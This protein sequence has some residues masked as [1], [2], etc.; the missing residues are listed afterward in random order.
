MKLDKQKL[1][2]SFV[3]SG[4]YDKSIYF[5]ILLMCVS[6]FTEFAFLYADTISPLIENVFIAFGI[7][8][9]FVGVIEGLNYFGL[10][11]SLVCL[12]NGSW[13]SALIVFLLIYCAAK[14]V[15]VGISIGGAIKAVEYQ[16]QPP[17][18]ITQVY[19]DSIQNYYTNK[20]SELMASPHD[21]NQAKAD[22]LKQMNKSILSE[23]ESL[24]K[25]K[26]NYVGEELMYRVRKIISN[27][28]R[29]INK[30][31][32]KIN[33]I[34]SSNSGVANATEQAQKMREE[35]KNKVS[36]IDK[37]K[38][39]FDNS[40]G[41]KNSEAKYIII[42]VEFFAFILNL[43]RTFTSI[44]KTP[45]SEDDIKAREREMKK[46]IKLLRLEEQVQKTKEDHL[47]IIFKKLDKKQISTNMAKD[48]TSKVMG[49]HSINAKKFGLMFTNWKQNKTF[50]ND[51]EQNQT[52]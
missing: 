20:I 1:A 29:I 25:D 4:F 38:S 23:I 36:E 46:E 9:L 49:Q 40:V 17:Y 19:K 31:R 3:Q 41:K 27:K 22:Q 45:S 13:E 43:L 37:N 24:R 18:E 34:I 51:L 28:E 33:D 6:G 14:V 7:T 26:G 39:D 48:M 42:V 52:I 2:D 44:F 15:S 8:A 10:K 32:D 12:K 30:N 35:L 50:S 16:K 5:I 47:N 11:S 21:I